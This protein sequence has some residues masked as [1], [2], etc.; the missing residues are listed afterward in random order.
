MARVSAGGN[1]GHVLLVEDDRE[2]SA[3][4][5]EL[6]LSQDVLLNG[7]LAKLY[8]ANLPSNSPFRSVR[9]DPT[10]RA[11]VL[12][13]EELRIAR[14]DPSFVHVAEDGSGFADRESS[15]AQASAARA[16]VPSSGKP[17]RVAQR[18]ESRYEYLYRAEPAVVAHAM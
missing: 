18:S 17:V 11:G 2:V 9:L 14:L 4:T 13:G 1:G 15:A 10:E 12:T 7:R 16:A 8:G 3:L 6:L 5:R